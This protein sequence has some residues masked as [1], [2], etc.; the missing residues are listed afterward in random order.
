MALTPEQIETFA[1]E[2]YL[3]G[4]DVS[5]PGDADSTRRA[6]DDFEARAGRQQCQEGPRNLHFDQPFAWELAINPQVLDCAESLLGPELLLLGTRTFCKY[7]P[8]DD[9]VAWHQDLKYW[10]LDP[11]VAINA[12]MAIDDSDAGNGCVRFIPGSHKWPF[13]EHGVASQAGN[14]LVNNQELCVSD[15]EER[16][17]VDIELKAGQISIHHGMMAH[18][19]LPNP[20]QRRRCGIALVYVPAFVKPVERNE[21]LWTVVRVRGQDGECHF[22]HRAPPF[23]T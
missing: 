5:A 11:A 18:G 4:I 3:A 9:F 17:A 10:G 21:S 19:S 14:L 7:G 8:S 2:G 1:A 22:D 12:W 16:Q 23:P 15:E 20:S 13:R 6:F